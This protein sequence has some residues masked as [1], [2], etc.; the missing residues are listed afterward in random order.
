[1]SCNYTFLN[2]L[3]VKQSLKDFIPKISNFELF[4]IKVKSLNF[5]KF[6][7]NI[8]KPKKEKLKNAFVIKK[9]KRDI[10]PNKY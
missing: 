9:K 8:T 5:N 6:F 1:M 4:L 2:N 7:N 3:S 10:I